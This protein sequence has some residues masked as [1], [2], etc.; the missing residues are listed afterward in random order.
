M[1]SDETE[2]VDPLVVAA[3]Q[4]L[5]EFKKNNLT[6][7]EA[8]KRFKHFTGLSD[9]IT[10]KFITSMVKQNNSNNV[11]PFPKRKKS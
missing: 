11:I 4:V 10:Q 7:K 8:R 6:Y 5:I 9:E 1:A 3:I 2:T